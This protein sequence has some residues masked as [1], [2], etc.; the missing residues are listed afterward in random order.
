MNIKELKKDIL[1]YDLYNL[2]DG[3]PYGKY[4]LT[5]LNEGDK[6]LIILNDNEGSASWMMDKEDFLS[7]N[8]TEDLKKYIN[9][10]LYYNYIKGE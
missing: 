9:T 8:T 4:L 6:I 2:V 1:D 5:I 7:I 3:V 10:I